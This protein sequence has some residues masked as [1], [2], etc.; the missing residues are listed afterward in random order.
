MKAM[1]ERQRKQQSGKQALEEIENQ[2]VSSLEFLSQARWNGTRAARSSN[3]K[4]KMK[5]SMHHNTFFCGGHVLLYFVMTHESTAV[6]SL[7]LKYCRCLTD[8][9]EYAQYYY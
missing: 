2:L 5:Y 4:A 1:V 3:F 8:L 7:Y 9:I 6:F